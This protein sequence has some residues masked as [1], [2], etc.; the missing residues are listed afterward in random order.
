MHPAEHHLHRLARAVVD[1][2]EMSPFA[3]DDHGAVKTIPPG[4]S[5]HRWQRE[6]SVLLLMSCWTR[7]QISA[8]GIG[9][10]KPQSGL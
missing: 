8:G 10:T 7:S 9:L 1:P 4:R 5:G 6:Q 3:K 2:F